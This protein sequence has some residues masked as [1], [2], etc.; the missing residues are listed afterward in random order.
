MSL[1]K[2]DGSTPYTSDEIGDTLE[3]RLRAGI[4]G[5]RLDISFDLFP[6]PT[7][8]WLPG[9][10]RYA[11]TLGADGLP[12]SYAIG[13]NAGIVAVPE[14]PA[15]LM[16]LTAAVALPLWLRLRLRPQSSSAASTGS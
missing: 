3:G 16:A 6:S 11:V 2:P 10:T 12:I 13:M 7:N 1:L 14:P 15:W 4:V 8:P 5:A 9:S